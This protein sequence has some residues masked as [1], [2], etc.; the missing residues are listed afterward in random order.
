M[1]LSWVM[2]THVGDFR[3]SKM[4]L[5]VSEVDSSCRQ[6]SVLASALISLSWGKNTHTAN[7]LIHW[8]AILKI[9][10]AQMHI[11][12]TSEDCCGRRGDPGG[13]VKLHAARDSAIDMS[14][15]L[16]PLEG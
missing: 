8:V 3:P 2:M 14:L 1:V 12:R 5:R 6:S 13:S 7:H 4:N 10:V 16:G 9:E 15:V 11:N